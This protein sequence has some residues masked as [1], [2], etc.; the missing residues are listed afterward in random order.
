M[1]SRQF[2]R[3]FCTDS[4]KC[5]KWVSF[6]YA[7]WPWRIFSGVSHMLFVFLNG[8][9]PVVYTMIEEI[10]GKTNIDFVFF[11]FQV[12]LISLDT[13]IRFFMLPLSLQ[14]IFIF[15]EFVV[16]LKMLFKLNNVSFLLT[17]NSIERSTNFIWNENELVF[18]VV[19]RFFF[20]SHMQN[21]SMDRWH[22]EK[23]KTK[24]QNDEQRE[25]EREEKNEQRLL[26]VRE[27]EKELYKK[28]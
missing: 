25:R 8:F 3:V 12:D 22:E 5:L 17:F 6:I 4:I 19:T 7:L 15:T 11:L 27:E 14:F 20:S 2:M 23:K 18:N 9:F 10:Q 24:D 21:M 28:N 26:S 1:L 16:C 13:V